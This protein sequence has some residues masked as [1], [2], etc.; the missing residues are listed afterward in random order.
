[1]NRLIRFHGVVISLL[2]HA[3]I[4]LGQ[5]TAPQLTSN[6]PAVLPPSPEAWQFTRYGN[7][8]IGLNTGAAQFSLPVY[9]ISTGSL[10]HAISISYS[11]N[12][13]KVDEQPGRTGLGWS[14]R[15][16][17]VITRSVMDKPDGGA[18]IQPTYYHGSI[19]TT[20][21]NWNL[22]NYAMQ[23]RN[24]MPPDFQPD[25]YSYSMDGYSG[26]FI[27]RENGAYTQYN[28]NGVKIEKNGNGFLLTAPNG[29]QYQ[30]YLSETASNYSYPVSTTLQWVPAPEPTAWY[31]TKI[32]A[33]NHSDEIVFNYASV[34]SAGITY[35]NG[36]SQEYATTM[37]SNDGYLSN[38]GYARIRYDGANEAVLTAGGCASTP[39]LSTIIQ[40]SG[41]NPYCLSSI[42][43][44]GGTVQFSYSGREDSPGE[45][46]LDQIS[47]FRNG[48]NYR[49]ASVEFDYTYS[50][51]AGDTYDT[52]V[53]GS[54]YTQQNPHLRK[55]L[56]LTAARAVADGLAPQTH[57]FEY[58]DM[59]G[60]PPRLSFS[61]DRYGSFNGKVNKDYFFPN[62]TWFDW[63]LGNNQ[64]GGNRNYSFI[65]AQKGAL[66]K[67]TYPTGGYTQITYGPNKIDGD[68]AYTI[69]SDSVWAL[70]DTSTY[71][72]QEAWSATIQHTGGN[73]RLRASCEW[74]T[75]P[76]GTSNGSG[77]F[78]GFEDQYYVIWFLI[79]DATGACVKACNKTLHVSQSA[80]DGHMGFGLPP[81]TYKIKM[82]AS[83]P[84]IRARISLERWSRQA[85]HSATAGIAGIRVQSIADF[86]NAGSM[87]GKREYLYGD[88]GNPSSSSGTGVYNDG[89]YTG[90][91]IGFVEVP[92]VAAGSASCGYNTISSS[93]MVS[94]FLT[95][96]GT[97][98]YTKVTELQTNA[99][100]TK[101]NGGAEH[102]FYFQQKKTAEPLTWNWYAGAWA[103]TQP[104]PT[105]PGAPLMNNDFLTGLPKNRKT[106]T[107]STLHGPRTILNET[108]N[109]Y[110]VHQPTLIID[111]FLVSKYARN[112]DCP[113]QAPCV[114]DI[115]PDKQTYL[116]Q[117]DLYRY[118][119]YFGFSK[120]DKTVTK[121]YTAAGTLENEITYSS[122]SPKNY[123][124]RMV[125]YL[126]GAGE[127]KTIYRKYAGDVLPGESGYST[128][129]VPMVNANMVDALVEESTDLQNVQQQKKRMVYGAFPAP[130]NG[131]QY[132]PVQILGSI[133]SAPEETEMNYQ[134]YD[135]SGNLLQY[136][137]RSGV[138]VA[139][140]W[141]YDR[142]Y[143]VAQITGK[144]YADAVA[145]SGINLAVVNNPASE[146]ALRGELDKLRSL[147]GCQVIS[148]TYSP[149]VGLASET[150]VAGKTQY[151][152]YDAFNRLAAIKDQDGNTLKTFSYQFKATA[153]Q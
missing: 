124:P 56:F 42:T 47:V 72:G 52:Y 103:T 143:P 74:A 142:K 89:L 2:L 30:F 25:E 137:G 6:I 111:T 8:P 116:Y 98:F 39:G 127:T 38:S 68:Y 7:L 43:F 110:S 134:Q 18:G 58:N 77:G 31:L 13:V 148:R 82:V 75:V 109:H 107:Y 121:E 66:K 3:T 36:I 35:Q 126:S 23:A 105:T 141:G 92:G 61:Q 45:K 128:I 132:L 95:D 60:L 64:F 59:N 24:Q 115:P 85:D 97:V 104:L 1:M 32:I 129:Y 51:V 27:K 112:I 16:G 81:G 15:A 14:L 33:P 49:R 133:N 53:A 96:N 118:W 123:Q 78:T 84:S 91:E 106:F 40:L 26:K 108:E 153:Q 29:V 65:H 70:L 99:D 152:V 55:R 139:I 67:I 87:A 17:G 102:E 69:Q 86:D 71:N 76:I 145:Q 21:G 54:N 12:G 73:L 125:N 20:A 147:G 120:L 114:T 41:N 100:G 113:E 150:D 28:A 101:N 136:T 4:T 83:N 63:H 11:T 93:S 10:S 140:I 131:T 119:R 90:R 34:N 80:V 50:A 144:N 48:D 37:L 135:N 5:G 122:H 19:A 146:T 79:D 44:S 138:T 62:D 88:W 22:Y 57:N 9:T 130:Q 46:K 151:Y 149:L 117:F 94:N